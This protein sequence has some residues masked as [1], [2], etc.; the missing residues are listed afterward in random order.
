MK[1]LKFLLIPKSNN[2][3]DIINIK[4]ISNELIKRGYL[5]I[6]LLSPVNDKNLEFILK[7]EKF[8]FVIRINK[9]KPENVKKRARFI[10]WINEISDVEETLNN[11]NENDLIYTLKQS[12]TQNKKIK[13]NQMLP[14]ANTFKNVLTISDYKSIIN[15]KNFQDIDISLIVNHTRAELFNGNKEIVLKVKT[16]NTKKSEYFHK[17][18]NELDKDYITQVHNFFDYSQVWKN[19]RIKYKG[20]INNFNY[21][22]EIFRNSK[23]NVLFEDEYLEFRTNFFNIL[24][25]EGTL[26]LNSKLLHQINKY[27]KLEEDSSNYFFKYSDIESFKFYISNYYDNFNKRLQVGKK[28]SSLIRKK[29]LYKNRVDQILK[30]LN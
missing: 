13:I 8:D 1:N 16:L 17:I 9:G 3:K 15:N 23:F 14:A 12:N 19:D 20:E 5:C 7:N 26:L 25:V 18:I 29:H 4:E 24:L 11:F 22:F 28:A 6:T 2:F 21:F 27:L 10:S 30:D